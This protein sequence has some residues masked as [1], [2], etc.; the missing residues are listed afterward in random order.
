MDWYF[1][2]SLWHFYSMFTPENKTQAAFAD[3]KLL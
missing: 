3:S 2:F 1:P